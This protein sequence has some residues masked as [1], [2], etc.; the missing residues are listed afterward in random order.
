MGGAPR[1]DRK[2]PPATPRAFM[3]VMLKPWLP[4]WDRLYTAVG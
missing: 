4:V 2:K 3:W 1:L